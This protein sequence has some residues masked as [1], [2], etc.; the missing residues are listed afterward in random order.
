MYWRQRIR[1]NTSLMLGWGK[2]YWAH[3]CMKCDKPHMVSGDSEEAHL[4][5]AIVCVLAVVDN[6]TVNIGAHISL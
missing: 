5:I 1:Q 4:L 2:L 3:S 6:A